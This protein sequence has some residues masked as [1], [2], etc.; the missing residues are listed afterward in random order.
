[1]PSCSTYYLTWVSLTLGMRYL[2]TATPAKCSRCSLPWTRG[3]L[4]T[5]TLPDLQCGIASLGPLAPVQPPL[6]GRG[7]GP[8]GHSP[9]PRAWGWSSRLQPLALGMGAWGSSSWQP[10]LTSDTGYLLSAAPGDLGCGV[11]PLSRSCAIAVWY[12]W[13]LPLTLDMG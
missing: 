12:P 2:F 1:M 9:W 11:A 7:V 6:L 8:P 4:L 5:T 3:S 10:S 13:P